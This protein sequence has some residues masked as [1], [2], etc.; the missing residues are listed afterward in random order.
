MY[1]IKAGCIANLG[2]DVEVDTTNNRAN[3]RCAVRMGKD[4]TEWLSVTAWGSKNGAGL[5]YL[6]KASKGSRLS[7]HGMTL[8][9]RVDK[10]GKT[11]LNGSVNAMDITVIPK[12]QKDDDLPF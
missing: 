12:T 10:D 6:S 2:T 9:T 7:I 1:G 3:F 8:T 4:Q 11:W 5:D